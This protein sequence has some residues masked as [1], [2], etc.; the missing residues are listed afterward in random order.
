[1]PVKIRINWNNENDDSN[2]VRIYRADAVFTSS[3]LPAVLTEVASTVY[4]YDD[5]TT[6][7]GQ[8]YYYMLSAKSVDQEV[9]TECSSVVAAPTPTSSNIGIAGTVG[10]GVGNVKVLPAGMTAMTGTYTAGH[11]NY[12]NYQYS[13]GSIMVWVPIF[14]YRWGHVNSPNYAKYGVNACDV[15][16]ATDFADVAAANAAGYA[17]HRAFYDGGQLKT[18]FFVDKYQ[19]SNNAGVASSLKNGNPLSTAAD[20]HPISALTGTPT[21]N[22]A[23]TLRA[24]KSRGTDF[25][26]TTIF[27]QR[28]LSLLSIAHAQAA[29][30]SAACAWYDATEVNNFPKGNNNNALRDVNDTSVLYTSTGYLQAG[31]TGS[32]L[33]FAKTTHNGQASGVA[34]LNGNMWE[35]AIGLTQTSGNFYVLKTSAKA[36]SLTGGTTLATDAWGMTAMTQSYDSLGAS[37]GELKGVAGAK[38]MGATSTQVLSSALSGL[39]WQASG[40]GIPQIGGANATGTNIFGSDIFYDAKIEAICPLVGGSWSNG[41][42]AGV[43][44]VLCGDSRANS[45][46]AVGFRAALYLA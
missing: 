29:T 16:T 11:E 2:S 28:A 46:S 40:A 19:C 25:F 18:G 33:P 9:F 17:V 14:Y 39:A 13:D 15:K 27:V 1:M 45:F 31:R 23:G 34:D 5:L 44:S 24:A 35:A 37:Y 3:T 8:T 12:G 7:N 43:W 4:E 36:S 30:S 21:N 20:N 38:Y 41:V 42:T 10:F 22:I 6:T 32:A 26:V